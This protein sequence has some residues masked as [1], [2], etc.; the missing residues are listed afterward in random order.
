MNK[1]FKKFNQTKVTHAFAGLVVFVLIFFPVFTHL[2]S[3][4]VRVWDEAR[5]AINAYEMSKN[6]QWFVTYF[7]GN[8]DLWNTKPPLLIWFQVFWIKLLGFNEL[9]IRMPSAIAAFF[10]LIIF[11]RFLKSTF[12]SSFLALIP[13]FVLL[14]NTGFLG[15]HAARNGDYDALLTLFTTTSALCFYRMLQTNQVKYFY[16]FFFSLTL[17]VLTKGV[18]GLLFL[19]AYFVF[20]LVF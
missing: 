8:P 1:L 11:F 13:V 7:E 18:A 12:N 16:Y 19:P 6:G 17:A 2:D 9:A 3:L 14:T 10:T 15:E 5:N 4:P 20:T